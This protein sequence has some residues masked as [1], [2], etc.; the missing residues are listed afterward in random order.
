M[1]A[2][3]SIGR[4]W[5][6]G[7]HWRPCTL[8]LPLRVGGKQS[9]GPAF[10]P[11]LTSSVSA[12]PAP[13]GGDRP[14]GG[15]DL[16]QGRSRAAAAVGPQHRGPVPGRQHD[17]GRGGRQGHPHRRLAGWLACWRCAGPAGAGWRRRGR[18]CSGLEAGTA[19]QAAAS[20]LQP[21]G[22]MPAGG[23]CWQRAAACPVHISPVATAEIVKL[24]GSKGLA[25]AFPTGGRGPRGGGEGG[26]PSWQQ[27]P[28][29]PSPATSPG[30]VAPGRRTTV[31]APAP[32]RKRMLPLHDRPFEHP[33]TPAHSPPAWA[34]K[35]S[36]QK[37][38]TPHLCGPSLPPTRSCT[39][40]R[41]ARFRCT[42]EA[43]APGGQDAVYNA[44]PF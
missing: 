31:A 1:R 42:G 30:A 39:T 33:D 9:E 5:V 29:S 2:G 36:E 16:L 22:G 24:H 17:C 41:R 44:W 11:P 38:P 23:S 21:E 27:L 18:A 37:Q 35:T 12:W 15:P 32:L 19:R 10:L 28:G 26:I 25:R 40:E 14:G 13:A 43:P 34:R 8:P 20:A 6:L 4:H 7:G 3:C